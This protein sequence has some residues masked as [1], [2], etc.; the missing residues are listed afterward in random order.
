MHMDSFELIPA[1]NQNV[2][3]IVHIT[4][5]ISPLFGTN[6]AFELFGYNRRSFAPQNYTAYCLDLSSAAAQSNAPIKCHTEYSFCESY[7]QPAFAA[8]TL[9]SAPTRTPA[10]HTAH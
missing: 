6:P 5:A 10:S 8:A 2:V 1:A 7:C 4:P 9:I 3:S